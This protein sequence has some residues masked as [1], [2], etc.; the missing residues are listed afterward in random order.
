[1]RPD[2]IRDMLRRQPFLP[3]RLHLSNGQTFDIR[4]PEVALVTRMGI[5]IAIPGSAAT[6]SVPDRFDIVSPLHINNIEML[7]VGTSTTASGSGE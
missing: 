6:E 4:H 7:P 3:F 1:M 2:D 5:V